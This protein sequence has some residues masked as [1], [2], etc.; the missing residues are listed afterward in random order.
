M[1]SCRPLRVLG[2]AFRPYQCSGDSPIAYERGVST[3]LKKICVVFFDDILIYIR[4]WD[5]HYTHLS[6]V[7]SVLEKERLFANQKKRIFGQSQ[8][9]YLGHVISGLGVL[10]DSS[11]IQA[12]TTSPTPI[13]VRDVR[14]F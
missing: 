5:E 2:H 13:N 11:K 4:T 8:I 7:L 10:A 9:D 12:M 1:H 6:L 3:L 14:G